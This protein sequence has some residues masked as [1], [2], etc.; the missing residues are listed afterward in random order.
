MSGNAAI[1][2]RNPAL[3]SMAGV[4][5]GK[6]LDL[7]DVA[8]AVQQFG[9]Q[10]AGRTP[11]RPVICAD[12]RRVRVALDVR[13]RARSPGSLHSNARFDHGG[14][15]LRLVRRDDQ[16][17]NLLPEEILDVGD[18]FCIVLLR[19]RVDE[20]QL[21]RALAASAMS[22]FIATRHGS[23]R[24]ACEKPIRFLPLCSFPQPATSATREQ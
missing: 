13:G 14:Q 24:L 10:L 7:D 8:L 18:L 4:E 6:S 2:S 9:G 15:G 11:D 21:G 12:E 1:A 16:Q 3:R 17:I 19:V 20:L 5:P 22:A 23:P